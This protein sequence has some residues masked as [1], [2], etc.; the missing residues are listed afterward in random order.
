MPLASKRKHNCS[1]AVVLPTPSV[2]SKLIKRPKVGAVSVFKAL[3]SGR[4]D[5]GVLVGDGV[6]LVYIDTDM[7]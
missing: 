1:I 3:D 2:P 5:N 7:I 6:A 4:F